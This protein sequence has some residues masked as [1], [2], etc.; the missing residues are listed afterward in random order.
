MT[1]PFGP[2]QPLSGAAVGARLF[3]DWLA[4][5]VAIPE[6]DRRWCARDELLRA[7]RIS[8]GAPQWLPE[9]EA[10]SAEPETVVT[11][12]QPGLLGGPLYTLL[13]IATTVAL[14]RRRT[15][16]GRPT[17]PV[18]WSADDDDDWAEA[19]EPVGWIPGERRLRRLPAPVPEEGRG[20]PRPVGDLP[21]AGR[22]RE[23][24]EWIAA[25]AS[26]QAAAG[27]KPLA[28]ELLEL[29]TRARD[30]EWTWARLQRALLERLFP[31]TGLRVVSGNDP[32]LHQAAAPVYERMEPALESLVG[33]AAERGRALSAAGWHAQIREGSL[34]RPL[35][36]MSGGRRVHVE[37]QPWPAARDLRPGVLLRSPLQDWLLRPA[38]VVVGPGELSYLRQLDPV[39]D[40]LGLEAPPRVPRLFAWCVP[41]DLPDDMLIGH[42][43]A[44]GPPPERI[45]RLADS[46]AERTAGILGEV[47]AREL[48]LEPER[49][50]ELARGRARRFRKGVASLL[51]G[52]A[53][54]IANEAA[55]TEPVWV[56]PDGGRQERALASTGAAALWG[57]ELIDT[58]LAAADDHLR[59]GESGDWSEY[60]IEVK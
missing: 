19:F 60:R 10:E 14:A 40:E 37:T 30:G 38:A 20:R 25:I 26:V 24:I 55:V 12:Q 39:Y 28:A 13:K 51:A 31:G 32:L 45:E 46:V 5:G 34:R 29:H 56:F 52:E 9:G 18:F 35:F 2:L 33:A 1:Y 57:D 53:R 42:G 21:V 59:R 15:E 23:A 54:R 6:D 48:E 16:A 47:L 36:V 4:G 44:A 17:V 8:P 11:G 3:R 49:A 50:E 43:H 27:A 7:M 58:L 41:G 22:G